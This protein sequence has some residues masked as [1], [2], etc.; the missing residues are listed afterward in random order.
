MGHTGRQRVA[1]LL[2]ACVLVLVD[3]ARPVAAQGATVV[4]EST[5]GERAFCSADTSQGVTLQRQ[6]GDAPCKGNWGS[7]ESGIW[8]ANGCRGEFLL[9]QASGR[10]DAGANLADVLVGVLGGGQGAAPSGSQGLLACESKDNRRVTCPADTR[11]GVVLVRQ[12]SKAPC[13][14]H[15][16]QTADAIWV[17]G[18][19]RAEFV[20][21]PV[22]P[23]PPA[24]PTPAV[25]PTP[26]R[27]GPIVRSVQTM[28]PTPAPEQ[29][30]VC[31]SQDNRRA[32]CSADTRGGVDLRRQLGQVPCLGHWGYDSDGVWVDKGC[33]AEFRVQPVGSVAVAQ[34][35]TVVCS[36][37]NNRRSFCSAD[38]RNGVA[39]Q[40]ELSDGACIGSWGYDE[41][42]IWVDNGCRAEFRTTKVTPSPTPLPGPGSVVTCES[43][44]NQRTYCQADTRT[45]VKLQRQLSSSACVGHWGYDAGGIWVDSGCR[46][47][48]LI[49]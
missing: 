1:V 40:R 27:R 31:E 9:G 12:L 47:E 16:G 37:K 28:T 29:T 43:Q 36:S 26:V 2:T 11:G 20:V 4:C 7:D 32:F 22:P 13:A 38:T 24:T 8:V 41:D 21:T 25:T 30:L 3:W 49:R 15:W 46:A 17:D 14:G 5:Q 18:G 42:G 48:L 35:G 45:G 39:L 34:T 23:P 33:R 19:C 10:V 6:L 44:G